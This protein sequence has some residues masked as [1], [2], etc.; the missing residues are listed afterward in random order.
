M[1]YLNNLYTA[2]SVGRTENRAKT[3]T[4]SGSPLLDFYAQAGAMRERPEQALELFKKA[5]SENQLYAIRILFYLRDVRG[6]Q[7]E[8]DLFRSCLE[9][10]GTN[11]T[12]VFEAIVKYV[13]DYG[14]W[15]DLFF[16]NAVALDAIKTQLNSDTEDEAPSLLAKWLPT[17]NASSKTTK[18]KAVWMKDK[19]GM[20]DIQYRKTIRDIRKKIAAVEEKMSANKWEDIDYSTVPSQ[21][22]RIYK[23]AFA[24]HDETRY[25]EYLSS[26]MKGEST[27]NASTLY[28]Y[29][30]YKDIVQDNNDTSNALWQS[31]PDYTQGKNALVVADV[32]GS[33]RGDP[34]AVSVS[35][36]L[37]FAE[38]NDGYFKDHLM[39]FSSSPK[40]QR[41][42]GD[43]LFAKMQSIQRA[44]WEMN[45]DLQARESI[46]GTFGVGD[47]LHP[48]EET[49]ANEAKY[50]E[51]SYNLLKI[52]AKIYT[53][54]EDIMRTVINPQTINIQTTAWALKKKRNDEAA[55]A[56][57]AGI[58]DNVNV[59]VIDT[60]AAGAFHSTNKI[61]SNISGVI[62]DHLK[63]NDSLL[64]HIAMNPKDL[65]K[66]TENT[67]TSTGPVNMQFNRLIG[68]GVIPFPG[69]S[70]LT[71]VVDPAIAEGVA[72]LVDKVNGSRLAEGPK[73]TRR[74][75]DE[76][77]DAE[78]I[79]MLDFN[80]YLIV[81][82]DQS[83]VTRT[84]NK[85]ITFAD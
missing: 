14:R 1:K 8:R 38:R 30:I 53:P 57:V 62:N 61:A 11:H 74:Y 51:I 18:A 33:M 26:V 17:I 45:T 35:L 76:E 52:P 65:A 64:T 10:V 68:A 73:T 41:I 16:D 56:I 13:S 48:L 60:L 20:T 40:L 82:P 4:R 12:D 39:T 9:W 7:G 79:K 85:K 83:K 32:S 63:A 78:V 24:K 59:G 75:F 77:R 72:Y 58:T 70:G 43:T 15:D 5:F 31:L 80:Q 25:N 19:L 50:D 67:W 69:V 84:F 81:N 44:D 21:A 2:T 46:Q 27:I 23:K 29:Q 34:I 47:Y 71:A 6:G 22:A 28:P 37:Y 49:E 54:I 36:A 55:K 3:F 66:Y 42:Q